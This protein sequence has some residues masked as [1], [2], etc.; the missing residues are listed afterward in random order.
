MG[1]LSHLL[2]LGMEAHHVSISTCRIVIRRIVIIR[3]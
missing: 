1:K 3:V 2:E